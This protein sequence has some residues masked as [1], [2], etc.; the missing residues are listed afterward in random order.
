MMIK[1][2]KE[3]DLVYRN[4]PTSGYHS[5]WEIP[6]DHYFYSL[7][8]LFSL[9]RK[10][11]QDRLCWQWELVTKMEQLSEVLFGDLTPS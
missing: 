9:W 6:T 3:K 8:H 1:G 2:T 7:P 4:Y 10:E 5:E 11:S